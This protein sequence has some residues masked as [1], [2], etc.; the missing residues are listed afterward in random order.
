[1]DVVKGDSIRDPAAEMLRH[2]KGTWITSDRTVTGDAFKPDL[3]GVS[4]TWLQYFQGSRNDQLKAARETI[5]NSR[6]V[7]RN[8]RLAVLNIEAISSVG[9]ASGL[10]LWVEHDPI[11]DPPPNQAHCLI[12]GVPFENTVVHEA[13]ALKAAVVAALI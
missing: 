10:Q 11:E 8:H 4:V 2:C 13:L 12:K 7:R 5:A 9:A 6:T 1:M 3:D